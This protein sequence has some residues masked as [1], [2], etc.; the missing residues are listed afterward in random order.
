MCIYKARNH[1]NKAKKDF[2]EKENENRLTSKKEGN[3]IGSE[4]AMDTRCKNERKRLYEG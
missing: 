4:N 1:R 3:I 2:L